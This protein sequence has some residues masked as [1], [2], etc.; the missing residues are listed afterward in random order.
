MTCFNT[1]LAPQALEDVKNV[2][3]KNLTD[4]VHD[5]GL[6][7]KG[8]AAFVK[9][10]T[11]YFFIP[12]KEYPDCF[13]PPQVSF[14]YILSLSKEEGMRPRGRYCGGLDMM[15]ILSCIR[16]I[17]FPRKKCHFPLVTLSASHIL[18]SWLEAAA[19]YYTSFLIPIQLACLR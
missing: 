1:P 15:T 10:N 2:V 3:S 7:L 13:F 19:S 6:T 17:C 5:N 9:L 16:T 18:L 8:K 14:S 4:G 12:E 11:A